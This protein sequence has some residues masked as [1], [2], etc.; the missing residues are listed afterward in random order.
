MATSPEIKIV[1]ETFPCKKRASGNPTENMLYLFLQNLQKVSLKKWALLREPGE[2]FSTYILRL[3]SDDY[4]TE[5]HLKFMNQ[6]ENKVLETKIFRC[7]SFETGGLQKLVE[8]KL[9]TQKDF[10]DISSLGALTDF[11]DATKSEKLVSILL[12]SSRRKQRGKRMLFAYWTLFFIEKEM[13]IIEANKDI[14]STEEEREKRIQHMRLALTKNRLKFEFDMICMQFDLPIWSHTEM[15]FDYTGD[16]KRMKFTKRQSDVWAIYELETHGGTMNGTYAR[17]ESRLN[18]LKMFQS[19]KLYYW[20][21]LKTPAELASGRDVE[22]WGD[23]IFAKMIE[24]MR[25]PLEDYLSA[26]FETDSGPSLKRFRK[27]LSELGMVE[28]PQKEE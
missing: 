10:E 18:L 22:N 21:R 13:K 17:M 19:P 6:K 11:E 24:K 12:D 5:E 4:N 14:E 1:G 2:E 9:L 25:G 23:K 27:Y 8:H 28:I 20:I 7:I 15:P 3:L 16:F 26:E